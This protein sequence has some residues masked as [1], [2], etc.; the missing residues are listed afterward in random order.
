MFI[1]YINVLSCRVF[2]AQMKQ[3]KYNY[4]KLAP[5][6]QFV[7]LIV[8]LSGAVICIIYFAVGLW[9]CEKRA[10]M[11]FLYC[12]PTDKQINKYKKLSWIERF[13][14]NE[15]IRQIKEKQ[16]ELDEY[17]REYMIN[18]QNKNKADKIT[19]A[20]LRRVKKNLS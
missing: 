20:K 2:I 15:C 18:E 19:E 3:I 5:F 11:D 7:L 14:I 8:L 9:T 12:R 6:E 13:A 16:R 10:A 1:Y 4:E 17:R